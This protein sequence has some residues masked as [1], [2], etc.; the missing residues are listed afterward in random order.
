MV[1]IEFSFKWLWNTMYS[2]KDTS[3]HTTND[4]IGVPF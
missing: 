4:E 1:V 2:N 3:K